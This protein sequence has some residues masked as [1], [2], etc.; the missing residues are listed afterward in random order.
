MRVE[1]KFL[2]RA[3]LKETDL[4]EKYVVPYVDKIVRTKKLV[5]VVAFG[6]FCVRV[7]ANGWI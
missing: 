4:Y 5:G 1:K 6:R 2:I 3:N 7:G